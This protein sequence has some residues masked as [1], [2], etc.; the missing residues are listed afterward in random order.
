ML[1]KKDDL[2]K[3]L[4]ESA[5][6]PGMDEETLMSLASGSDQN[7]FACLI[8]DDAASSNVSFLEGLHP[9]LLDFL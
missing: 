5:S 4:K 7:V 8:T 9:F 1:G 2:I 6:G 3:R